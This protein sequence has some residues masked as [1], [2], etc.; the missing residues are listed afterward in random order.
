MCMFERS[1]YEKMGMIAEPHSVIAKSAHACVNTACNSL[2]P[3]DRVSSIR[4]RTYSSGGAVKVGRSS[5]SAGLEQRE[6]W[7]KRKQEWD[8]PEPAIHMRDGQ[9]DERKKA[10]G[11]CRAKGG[12]GAILAAVGR[13]DH[14]GGACHHDGKAGQRDQS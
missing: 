3:V 1:I 4:V 11:G 14:D 6:R 13:H 8:H 9:K 7:G 10:Q 2:R 5:S 12:Q